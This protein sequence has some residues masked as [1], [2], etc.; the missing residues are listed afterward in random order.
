MSTR[1]LLITG[2]AGKLGRATLEHLVAK[3]GASRIVATTRNPE[4]LSEYAERG[5]DVRKA[6]FD[7]SASLDAAFQGVQRLLIVSTDALD[8]PGHRFDQHKRAI[9][10]AIRAGV[11]H[12]LYTSVV[13]A[14]EESSPLILGIDHRETEKVIKAS[15]LGYSILRNNWYAENLEG[16][17]RYALVAGSLALATGEGKVGWIL[18]DDCARAAAA[19][20]SDG[21]EGERILDITGPEALS[22]AEISAALSEVSGKAIAPAPVPPEI[23]KTILVGVGLPEGFADILVNSEESIA[24][25]WLSTAPG[26]VQ[27]LTGTVPRPLA[28]FLRT[29]V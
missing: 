20:L 14:D 7:D 15:G 21:F 5:V 25:G 8:Y 16:D 29:L 28:E 18:R 9:E 4:S 17:A 12:I 19:A 2:A 26:D 10:S 3:V 13:R 22:L 11:K 1:D 23:R 6:D 24:Q 27:K